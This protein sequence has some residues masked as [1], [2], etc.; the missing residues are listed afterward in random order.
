MPAVTTTARPT[1]AAHHT[2]T[3]TL[4]R[5]FTAPGPLAPCTSRTSPR[6]TQRFT[7]GTSQL[8][9]AHGMV[10]GRG[11]GERS[12]ALRRQRANHTRKSTTAAVIVYTLTV[13]AVAYA[14]E[15][16][17]CGCRW[18]ARMVTPR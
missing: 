17:S 12:W 9:T 7:T 8:A 16:V 5:P 10:P 11:V 6:G 14:L 4:S 13:D 3:R 18:Y 15:D 1:Q 2:F